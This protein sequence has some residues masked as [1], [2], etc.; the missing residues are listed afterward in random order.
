[1]TEKNINP[2]QYTKQNIYEKSK[3]KI[4]VNSYFTNTAPISELI[5]QIISKNIE[6]NVA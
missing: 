3:G 6:S 4:V 5:Y 1:M 2:I